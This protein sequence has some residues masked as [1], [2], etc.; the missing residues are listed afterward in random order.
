MEKILFKV[1]FC[2]CLW[3]QAGTRW[4][5]AISTTAGGSDIAFQNDNGQV[6]IRAMNGTSV[7]HI[8]INGFNPGSVW[9]IV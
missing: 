9:H 6:A 4:K 1:P 3:A 7:Q 8:D 2:S 5:P